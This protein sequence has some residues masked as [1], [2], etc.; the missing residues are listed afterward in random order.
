MAQTLVNVTDRASGRGDSQMLLPPELKSDRDQVIPWLRA[1]R[2]GDFTLKINPSPGTTALSQAQPQ[3][4][5]VPGPAPPSLL[6][7][8]QFCRVLLLQ[9]SNCTLSKPAFSALP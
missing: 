2:N 1:P 6:P 4:P 7:V 8:L 5:G 9:H 3:L